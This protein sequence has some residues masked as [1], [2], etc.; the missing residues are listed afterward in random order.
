MNNKPS[1]LIIIIILLLLFSFL[2]ICL[3]FEIAQRFLQFLH[4]GLV[5]ENLC[6]Q[7]IA[8][9][10]IEIFQSFA[11]KIIYFRQSGVTYRVDP[12]SNRFQFSGRQFTFVAEFLRVSQFR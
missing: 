4:H 6:T 10:M 11:L 9:H 5:K 7:K 3:R 1:K 12:R 2:L 8:N